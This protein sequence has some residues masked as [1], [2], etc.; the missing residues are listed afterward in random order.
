[1]LAAQGERATMTAICHQ[2]GLTERYFYESF[3]NRDAALVAALDQVTEEIASDSIGVLQASSGS[4]EERVHAMTRAFA[5]WAAEQPD[6]AHGRR[7]CTR[8]PPAHC[9]SAGT[10]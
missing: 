10:S 2:A 1:M 3:P 4:A 8:T 9:A 7:S 5:H 6:R